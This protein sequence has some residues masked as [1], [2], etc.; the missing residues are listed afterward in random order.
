MK[1]R[2]IARVNYLVDWIV[3]TREIEKRRQYTSSMCGRYVSPDQ[4]AMEREYA[5]TARNIEAFLSEGI[6]PSYNV[7]PTMRVPVLRV[8][9][10]Q[11][12]ERK[13]EAMRWGLIPFWSKGV[14]L[15]ASTI[16][17]RVESIETT[18]AYRDAWKRGQRCIF[19]ASGFYEWRI[20]DDG[21]KQPY[22]IRPSGDDELFSIAG[23]WDATYTE[24]GEKILSCVILTMEANELLAD[25]HNSQRRMP[26]IVP[27]EA[28]DV[29]L[30]GS[31]EDA[32]AL[33]QPYPS[34]LMRAHP[35]SKL[36]N[37]PKNDMPQCIEPLAVS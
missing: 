32:K 30:S 2:R 17:A 23:L 4:A 3:E 1:R 19:P 27:R 29:W 21:N 11:G 9:R 5:L 31:V 7:A 18:A 10:D 8:I 12:G 16:N 33:I 25:I 20:M 6:P 36:V 26:L 35:V 37:T 15:K 22:Y 34:E 13:L 28:I 14:P 24:S